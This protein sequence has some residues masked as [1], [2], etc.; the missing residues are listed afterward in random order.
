[1]HKRKQVENDQG[2]GTDYVTTP[3]KSSQH[4]RDDDSS[5]RDG[6]FTKLMR[7]N[8]MENLLKPVTATEPVTNSVTLLKERL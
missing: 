3:E 8:I 6:N 7:N 1:M 5:L 2:L 4:H